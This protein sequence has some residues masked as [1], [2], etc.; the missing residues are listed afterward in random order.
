MAVDAEEL[1]IRPFRD[2]V[3]LGA[4]AVTNAETHASHEHAGRMSKAAQAVVREG[5]RALTKVQ[6]VWNDQVARYGNSF[7]ET[8][9]EQ[10]KK[11][12]SLQS[13]AYFVLPIPLLRFA[14]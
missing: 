8:I 6:L 10:G 3:A 11:G 5:E 2:V 4:V 9:V 7:R 1:L 14:R 12:P 13:M